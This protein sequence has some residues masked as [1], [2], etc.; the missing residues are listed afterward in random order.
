MPLSPQ[1]LR[2]LAVFVVMCRVSDT[3]AE[4][5]PLAWPYRPEKD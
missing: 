4:A 2:P 5:A 3:S 1:N